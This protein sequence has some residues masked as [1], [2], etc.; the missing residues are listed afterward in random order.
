VAQISDG[1]RALGS[2]E[3]TSHSAFAHDALWRGSLRAVAALLVIGLVAGLLAQAL[4]ARIR[5]PLDDTVDQAQRLLAGEFITKPEPAAPELRRVTRAMNGLVSRLK[6]TF[7]AQ[8]S[9]LET[10]RR[11]AT[12]DPLTGLSNRKHFLGLL[13]V[14]LNREDGPVESSLLLIRVM[15]LAAVNRQIGHAATDRMILA[16]TEL[17]QAYTQRVPGCELGRL[18]GSDF[19]LCLPAGGVALETAQTLSDSLK[20]LLPRFGEGLGA[21]IAVAIGAVEMN[22]LR[23]L[24]QVMSAADGALALAES[25][26]GFSVEMS[27]QVEPKVGLVGAQ[28]WRQQIEAALRADAGGDAKLARFPLVNR[29]SELIHWEC[30][31]RLRLE[32]GGGFEPAARWLP[33]ALR[34]RLSAAADERAVALALAD[35]AQDGTARCINLSAASVLQAGFAPRLRALLME[36]PR[37]SRQLWLEVPE[38]AAV[39]HF[40]AVL[41]TG[42]QLRPTGIRWGIEHAGPQ[43]SQIDRLFE[44]GLDYA[45]LDASVTQGLAGD[46]QRMHFVR[47]IIVLLHGLA[48]QVFAEGVAN[49]ADAKALWQCGVDGITGP[50][51]SQERADLVG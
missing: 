31:L 5:R 45:K 39:E 29:A 42:R 28:V 32:Q 2:V 27:D 15:Q 50:W 33:L 48:V 3:V 7:D 26:G 40:D 44:A 37:A 16:V 9:Q 38:V 11:E 14:T 6:L 43:L 51:A 24:A 41:E 13:D 36:A 19:A 21:E 20:V 25:R 12:C 18:N 17:L 10:L 34:S 47:G 23:P 4:V 30:P 46:V 22:R 1:W 35:I 49:A 8:A